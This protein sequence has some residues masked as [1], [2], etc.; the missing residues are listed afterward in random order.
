MAECG[1]REWG[2]LLV[3]VSIAMNSEVHRTLRLTPHEIVF[4]QRMRIDDWLPIEEREQAMLHMAQDEKD[5]M[6]REI[7]E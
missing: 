3:E 5:R 2:S 7:E 6:V 1:T 4:N